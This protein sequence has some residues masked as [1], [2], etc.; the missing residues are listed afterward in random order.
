[1]GDYINTMFQHQM[2]YVIWYNELSYLTGR[3]VIVLAI[4]FFLGIVFMLFMMLVGC[5][6]E[7]FKKKRR[8]KNEK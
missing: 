5:L 6:E 4:G 1:M 3:D 2:D 8:T 7:D